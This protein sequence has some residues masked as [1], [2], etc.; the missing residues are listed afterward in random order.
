HHRDAVAEE[1]C[2]VPEGVHRRLHRSGQD[3]PPERDARGYRDGGARWDHVGAL[4]RVE[5]EDR[6]VDERRRALLD[7]TH[8]EV[9]VLHRPW[10]VA[11]LEWR[12]HRGVLARGYAALEHQNLSAPADARMQGADQDVPGARIG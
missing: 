10:K 3:G 11:L 4:V 7:D 2:G 9:A 12:P 8:I 6:A 1:R 5:A